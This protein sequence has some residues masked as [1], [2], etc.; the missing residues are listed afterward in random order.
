[1]NTL[2]SLFA[3][4]AD[5]ALK[6]AVLLGLA[7]VAGQACKN[8]SSASRHLLRAC[9]LCAALLLP[10]LSFLVPV[11]R[12][13]GVPQ[14]AAEQ[15]Q[16][17]SPQS[18]PSAAAPIA[19]LTIVAPLKHDAQP[20]EMREVAPSSTEETQSRR[21]TTAPDLQTA[22]DPHPAV[23]QRFFVSWQQVLS[24]IWLCGAVFFTF[25][26]LAGRLSLARL[27]RNSTPLIED[28]WSIE[29]RAFARSLGIQRPVALLQSTET[30]VPLTTGARRPKIIV[31]ADYAEW[32]AARRSAVLQHELAHIKRLDALTQ[33]VADLATVLYWFHP[34]VWIN[35]ISMRAERERACDDCVL[36]LGAKPSEYAHELLEIASSLQ[37]PGLGAAIAMARRSQL[38]GR[39]L[40]LLNPAL[41]RG[42]VSRKVV[43]T[44]AAFTLCIALPLAAIRAAQ[45]KPSPAVHDQATAPQAPTPGSRAK[46]NTENDEA[47]AP[48]PPEPSEPPEPAEAAAPPQVLMHELSELQARV[49]TLKVQIDVLRS[50]AQSSEVRSK[51]A[52][53][54]DIMAEV[55]AR[56]A[57]LQQQF[58][59]NALIAGGPVAPPPPGI[60]G[61]VAG[62]ITG[63]QPGGIMAGIPAVPSMPSVPSIPGVPGVPAVPAVPPRPVGELDICGS[64]AKLHNMSIDSDNGHQHWMAHWSGDDCSV[65]LLADGKIEFNADAN[66]IQSITAG[67]FFQVDQRQGNS[68]KQ[69]RVTPGSTGLQYV[70]KVNGTDQPFDAQAKDWLAKFLL[71]LERSTGFAAETRV[72]KLLAK[73][74]PGAV[75]EEINHLHGDYV[76]SIYFRKLLGEPN[77]PADVVVRVIN[78]A[79]E[80]IG[81]DYEKARVLMEVARQYPLQ[82]EGSRTAFLNA[83]GKMNSDYEHSRVLIE[84]L[85]RPN[86]SSH[87]VDLALHSAGSIRSD[88]EKSRILLSLMNQKSFDQAYLDFYL[89]MV[90]S[91]Q[92]DYEKSRDL[93]APMQKYPLE[94][95]QINQILDAT[96]TMGSD[97]EKSRLLT[98][99][100][101]KGRFDEKQMSEYLRVVE[102][103][104]SDY[105]RSRSLMALMEHNTLSKD[106]VGK[107][108]DTIGRMGSDYE[109]SRLL[110]TVAQKFSLDGTLRD[111]YVS[112]ANSLGEYERHRA[113]SAVVKPTSI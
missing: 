54:Q 64:H 6:A 8:R 110:L 48:E 101:D 107:V 69:V 77:L 49:M 63:G 100:V 24:M 25:R 38:E 21:A 92:S 99:L 26:I 56:L 18:M 96:T 4:V 19:N 52:A 37:Q 22:P 17:T 44:I 79:G 113:L 3:I 102:S 12:V 16:E 82:D 90:A 45:S 2:S 30:E 29:S 70:Y 33:V 87:L 93:L 106:S 43:L 98:G 89:K 10:L 50:L 86:I 59:S 36:A 80:Q 13:Q 53:L 39:L 76:R 57:N 62:G 27:V 81:S 109:K 32:T 103:M 51:E 47:E 60:P 91:I 65:D 35:A 41:S 78:Q 14:F 31:P 66:E 46:T 58:G 74:G 85:Q 7:W 68:W 83:A 11:W 104:G 28:G 61:G 94:Q 40:A 15:Q 72:H 73:G 88:Y 105:E 108:F 23:P 84:L 75:L 42:S 112:I 55:Q 97:Y 111:R 34:L 67:G 95:K 9:A 71:E 1:M 20:S 5:S